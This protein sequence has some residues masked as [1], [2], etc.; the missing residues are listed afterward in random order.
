METHRCSC[1]H[2]LSFGL[3]T[4]GRQKR[5][6]CN[7]N[8]CPARQIAPPPFPCSLA[9]PHPLPPLPAHSWNLLGSPPLA[10]L[11]NLMFPEHTLGLPE[12]LSILCGQERQ[13]VLYTPLGNRDVVTEAHLFGRMLLTKDTYFGAFWLEMF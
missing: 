9:Q 12:S 6:V 4:T 5:R 10:A 13:M 2:S 7:C 1:G 3:Q 8:L 11:G